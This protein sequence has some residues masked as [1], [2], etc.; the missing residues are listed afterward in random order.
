MGR[1][2]WLADDA[3]QDLIE[4][5]GTLAVV[6][7]LIGAV[8]A[9][10]PSLGRSITHGISCE[11]SAFLSVGSSSSCSS[12]P[13]ASAHGAGH[14]AGAPP[15]KAPTSLNKGTQLSQRYSKDAPSAAARERR[16]LGNFAPSG[17]KPPYGFWVSEAHGTKA[18]FYNELVLQGKWPPMP[19]NWLQM[20]VAQREKFDCEA[21]GHFADEQN[22]PEGDGGCGGNQQVRDQVLEGHITPGGVVNAFAVLGTGGL[23]EESEGLE[24]AAQTLLDDASTEGTEE[25][26][27]SE[28]DQAISRGTEKPDS[29]NPTPNTQDRDAG[30]RF[31]KG[32]S[33]QIAK[34]KE[35]QGLAAYE[36]DVGKPVIRQQVNASIPGQPAVSG[37]GRLYDGLVENADGTYRGIEIKSGSAIRK[38]GGTQKAFDDAVNSGHAA[39]AKLNGK[40]IKITSVVVREVP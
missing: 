14:T 26:S 24:T 40:T 12:Q 11:I 30:G 20:S 27:P 13:A 35:E 28:L 9:I 2:R 15:S 8:I 23:G 6:A 37:G 5:V 38:Y 22:N 17:A 25:L 33:G 4:Y 21:V 36:K 19:S 31:A 34:D 10:V 39:T 1:L 7:I 29:G 32:N 16:L 3:G 18:K